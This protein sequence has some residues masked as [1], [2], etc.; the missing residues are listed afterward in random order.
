MRNKT[1]ILISLLALVLM[2]GEGCEK[3]C[4]PKE[5]RCLEQRA[6]ICN[7]DGVWNDVIDCS[8]STPGGFVCCVKDG[9]AY[10]EQEALCQN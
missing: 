4:I 2:G 6:Q 9:D 10:C 7:S 1:L 5:T 8:E 3:G